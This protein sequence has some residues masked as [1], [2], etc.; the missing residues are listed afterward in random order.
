MA[1]KKLSSRQLA[2]LAVLETFPPKFDQI[3]RLI[4]EMATLRADEAMQRRLARMLDEMKAAA[5]GVGEGALGE[6]LGMMAMMARR[7]GGLQMR[8]RGLREGLGALKVNF[9]GAMKA[10]SN[11]EADVEEDE[12]RKS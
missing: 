2:T 4:E 11:P 10:A 5:T 6:T 12:I 1:M 7:T 3:F 9:E 8:V